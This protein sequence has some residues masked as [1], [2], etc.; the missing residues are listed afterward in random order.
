MAEVDFPVTVV[1][2][3]GR[4]TQTTAAALDLPSSMAV[5][6]G[7]VARQASVEAAAPG[8]TCLEATAAALV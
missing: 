3:H 7:K 1:W 2:L 6:V 4:T 8:K 5:R